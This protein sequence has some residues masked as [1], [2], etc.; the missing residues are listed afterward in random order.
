[1]FKVFFLEDGNK[2]SPDLVSRYPRFSELFKIWKLHKHMSSSQT[3]SSSPHLY[4]FI[5][6]KKIFKR[7]CV[8]V[9]WLGNTPNCLDYKWHSRRFF[10]LAIFLWVIRCSFR[11]L[12]RTVLWNPGFS[13][14]EAPNCLWAPQKKTCSQWKAISQG[15]GAIEAL[16]QG[17]FWA[18]REELGLN[19]KKT[20]LTEKVI[21]DK[22][23]N[24]QGSLIVATPISLWK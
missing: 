10:H 3:W 17:K 20:A 16:P 23:K 5:F 12:P 9:G 6:F 1:M 22:E 11:T 2:W 7:K 13:E 8:L 18:K 4:R 15:R 19:C 21:K 14:A 24:Y